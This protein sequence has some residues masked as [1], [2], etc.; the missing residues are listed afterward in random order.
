MKTKRNLIQTCLLV[1]VVFL[2]SAKA[3]AQADIV[4]TFD[5]DAEGWTV[6]VLDS[7]IYGNP[8]KV[9]SS[10]ELFYERNG[11]HP[12]GDIGSFDTD[13]KTEEHFVAPAKFLGNMSAYYGGVLSFDLWDSLD[14][15]V[16]GPNQVELIGNG[17]TLF[18]D[19]FDSHTNYSP[20]IT[21]TNWSIPLAPSAWWRLDDYSTT[22]NIPTAADFLAVLSN[23]QELNIEGD[24]SRAFPQIM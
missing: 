7:F 24:V 17:H 4:S 21:W 22:N 9:I 2:T 19:Y 14:P 6:E 18:Y 12:G 5:T 8:P 23:L 16:G 1:A 13:D 3:K 11:G 20:A 10:G 15:V